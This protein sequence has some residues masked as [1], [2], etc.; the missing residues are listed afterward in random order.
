[1][2]KETLMMILLPVMTVFSC[3]K[4]SPESLTWC[5]SGNG[6]VVAAGQP[7]SAQGG[8]EILARG[9]NAVDAAVATIF[10]LAV[11]D[12]GS[13]CIG[14]EVPFMFYSSETGKVIVFNGMGGAPGDS[15]AI[16]WCYRNGIPREG[17]RASTV[18]SA[19]STC[20]KALELKG[21]MSFAQVVKPVLDLLDAGKEDWHANLAS[22]FRRMI[23]TED[24]AA[25]TREEKIRQARDRF[26]KGDIADELNDYYIEAGAFLRKNDLEA[27][28]TLVEKPIFVNYRDYAV[29]KC[30]TWTQGAVLLQTLNLLENYDLSGMGFYSGDY[31]HLA[32]EAMKLAYADRD[33]YYGD[34]AF[35]NVPLQELLS[36]EYT[37]LRR[38]LI[39]KKKASSEIRPGDPFAMKA[40]AGTGEYRPGKSGTT[41]CVV[42]DKW[43]NVVAA[44]PSSN[45]EYGVCEKLGVA[46]N[47]R[48][49]SFNTRKGHPNALR[50]GKRPRI[51]LTPTIVLREDKP[52]LAISV[53][54]GDYQDQ[55][56]LQLLLDF[57]EFGMMPEQAV[58]VPRFWTYQLENSFNPS[59][60]RAS[61]I[62]NIGGLAISPSSEQQLIQDLEARGHKVELT[63]GES[64]IR[65][66]MVYLDQQSGF[67]YAAGE[68][69]YKYCAALNYP[70]IESE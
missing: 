55:M 6:G 59:P 60:D 31:V 63:K 16:D 19:L 56:A 65:P 5:A 67:F 3:K 45:T 13:F 42:V 25:G 2:K 41:T 10:C 36:E 9:G 52:V 20:L 17:I 35:E 11:S 14:G 34:P 50:P 51:T 24:Q 29:Y 40:L 64:Y 21:T 58:C 70:V 57:V 39:D 26:Y 30:N 54:G 23:E 46:H 49:G 4:E 68:P 33:R 38:P 12:Y 44:T 62:L 37:L 53:A 48:M 32:A 47:T 18:P 15:A 1:M 8:I 28:E 22:T 66:V 27:H 7:A 69:G 43:G 61:T